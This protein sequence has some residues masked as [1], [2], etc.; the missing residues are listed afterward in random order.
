MSNDTSPKIAIIGSGPSGC[1]LAQALM[2]AAKGAEIVIFDRLVSP[3]GLVRYGV[4]ADHQH[5][6]A[7]SRQFDR[8]FQG[9]DVR[10]AGDIEI[11]RDVSLSELREHFDAVA[12]ATG[13]A[14]DRGLGL[15][16]SELE[17]VIGAGTLT[18]ILNSHPGERDALPAL[19]SDVVVIG[20]GNV[21]LDALR[22][23]VKG[24]DDYAASDVSDAALDAYLAA[25]AERVT[26]ASRS[27]VAESK[28][29]AAMLKELAELPRARYALAGC[30]AR[31]PERESGPD[32]ESDPDRE[33]APDRA[34]DRAAAGR[35]AAVEALVSEARPAHPGPEVAL[36]FGHSPVRVLGE[37]RVE[38]VEFACGDE[39]VVVPATAVITAIGFASRDGAGDGADDGD[40]VAKLITELGADETSGRIEP[41][42]YRSGWA[43]RGPR[44]AIPENRTF[45]KA[46]AD[47]IAAD[48]ASGALGVSAERRGFAGLPDAVRSRAVSYEEWLVLEAHERELAPEGR[49]RRKLPHH[50][51]MVAIARGASPAGR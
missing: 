38:G 4:A 17:G 36:R 30:A 34:P 10:F 41:G 44:G 37:G 16:G 24:A 39:L 43:Q 6:K 13:L 9:G 12:L 31:G 23:L 32:R 8:L 42:L 46:V 7:I 22:F 18:R 26:L 15:P 5:T 29:D 14:A 2:R 48:L 45:A 50:E 19:G 40:E 35:I 49:V 21:A 33:S 25:P 51:T 1:Y 28:G 27:G 47:E 11:G 3:F 20:A